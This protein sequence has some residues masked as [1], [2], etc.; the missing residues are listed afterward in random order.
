MTGPALRLVANGLENPRVARAVLLVF[1]DKYGTNEWDFNDWPQRAHE[2]INNLLGSEH[3]N[4]NVEWRGDGP[5]SATLR[6]PFP[7][8][9]APISEIN[10]LWHRT[11]EQPA[12]AAEDM[13][14]AWTDRDSTDDSQHTLL[15]IPATEAGLLLP[16]EKARSGLA[17]LGPDGRLRSRTPMRPSARSLSA[18]GRPWLG[19]PDA[20][21][22][23]ASIDQDAV[24]IASSQVLLGPPDV[25]SWLRHQENDIDLSDH[26]YS[27]Y[28]DADAITR[29]ALG[30]DEQ[31]LLWLFDRMHALHYAALN[32]VKR[33]ATTDERKDEDGNSPAADRRLQQLLSSPG[34]MRLFGFAR[35]V[36]LE[37]DSD[38]PSK[39]LGVLELAAAG[40]D[41][42]TFLPRKTSFELKR[43]V[44]LF[45]PSTRA[46]YDDGSDPNLN[47][48]V[49]RLSNKPGGQSYYSAIS[50]EP[51]ASADEDIQGQT[52]NRNAR[53]TTGPLA[54][55]CCDPDSVALR[56]TYKGDIDFAEELSAPAADRLDIGIDTEDGAVLWYS[57]SPRTV[58]YSDPHPPKKANRDWPQRVID[59]LTPSWLPRFERDAGGLVSSTY[60]Q[61]D[62]KGALQPVPCFDP[63]MAAYSGEAIGARSRSIDISS[64]RPKWE[65]RPVVLFRDQDLVV[66]QQTIIP[67]QHGESLA[68]LRF[69]WSYHFGIRRA[70]LGGAG[71]TLQSAISLYDAKDSD[72]PFPPKKGGGFRYLR[73]DPISKP[74]VML[75]PDVSLRSK[76]QRI[77]LQTGAQMVLASRRLPGR[78]PNIDH[79]ARILM[80]PS[81]DPQFAAMHEAFDELGDHETVH[82]DIFVPISLTSGQDKTPPKQTRLPLATYAPPQGFRNA[83][84]YYNDP[85]P[86]K[87]LTGQHRFEFGSGEQR[88]SPYYP[89][90]AACYVVLRLQHP[91]QSDIWLSPPL[92]VR[93]RGDETQGEKR[94]SWP[95]LL[96]VR[97]DLLP[98]NGGDGLKLTGGETFEERGQ[99]FRRVTVHLLP[100]ESATLKAWAA[101]DAEDLLSWFDVIERSAQLCTAEGDACKCE[102]GLACAT[103]RLSLLGDQ[104]GPLQEDDLERRHLAGLYHQRLLEEPIFLFADVVDI[105][106]VHATDVPWHAASFAHVPH[107]ARPKSMKMEDLADFLTSA[108][109]A[110]DWGPAKADDNATAIVVGGTIEFDPTTTSGLVLE[111][112]MLQP[113][114]GVIDPAPLATPAQ[115]VP[116]P[117]KPIKF[118]NGKPNFGLLVWT[119]VLRIQGIPL[120]A[121]GRARKRRYALEELMLGSVAEMAAAQMQYGAPLNTGQA[122]QARFRIVPIPRYAPI[123]SNRTRE[124]LPNIPAPLMA[125]LS[126][127]TEQVWIPATIRPA[128]PDVKELAPTFTWTN[129]DVSAVATAVRITSSTTRSTELRL[130]LRRPWFSSGEHERVGIVFWP[131]PILDLPQAPGPGSNHEFEVPSRE[132]LTVLTEEDIG[133]VGPFVSVWGF[134]PIDATEP[135]Q[136]IVRPRFLSPD[137]IVLPDGAIKHPRVLM[138]LPGATPGKN[139]ER[140]VTVSVVSF[141]VTFVEGAIDG[142]VDLHFTPIKETSDPII[143]LGIVR[144]QLNA[145]LDSIMTPLESDPLSQAAI[146]CSPP[147]KVQCPF[148]PTRKLS[149][150]ATELSAKHG[151]AG[152]QT[153]ISVTLSGPA[154]PYAAGSSDTSV[155]IDLVEYIEGDEVSVRTVGGKAA[156]SEGKTSSVG[157]LHRQHKAGVT[158]WEAN[159]LL[160]GRL[161]SRQ[162]IARAQ[163][164]LFATGGNQD[165][166]QPR[167]FGQIPLAHPATPN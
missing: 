117:V 39:G 49:R 136:T 153:S 61:A 70:F 62:N 20:L 28:L 35:D 160:P 104:S 25:G 44:G 101:P 50:I 71:P 58:L 147:V 83:R 63:R 130:V 103:G 165:N 156:R 110:F 166:G 113:G 116:N 132:A 109:P 54:L 74:I 59:S 11:L 77:Q 67:T 46:A 3:T 99:L 127:T 87:G 75:A 90:P 100:G 9:K 4:V 123:L 145:R 19:H 88:T 1:P 21:V 167:Y 24:N 36:Y 146:R 7:K 151:A 106:V 95:N 42:E 98:A 43:E 52:N 31:D 155:V 32:G 78:G 121:D 2:L 154:D 65:T 148:V 5:Q 162:I 51:V 141:P 64:K 17:M 135:D 97:I 84:I 118:A 37:F 119:E 96:P 122:R 144:M 60:Q 23:V 93:V 13:L 27:A 111:A 163:E 150:T 53:V 126:P 40:A 108:G 34:L 38:L 15:P 143:R 105:S 80:I 125:G 164:D 16:L 85:S 81:V 33:I 82:G 140:F 12:N 92:V 138:P 55:V 137:D 142:Y 131:P 120:P 18:M 72:A 134:D 6:D 48:G 115:F 73:H 158:T 159:F 152:D 86:A 30:R 112:E 57:A 10:D 129:A 102:P 107:V 47:F 45:Y 66:D 91:E 128:A 8:Y 68:L 157:D 114:S 94:F 89:D 26:P 149:A 76:A 22:Q 133:P 29:A 124:P 161:G 56:A 139:D 41:A 69:G 79:T 14:K